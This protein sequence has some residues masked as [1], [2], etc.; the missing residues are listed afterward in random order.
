MG[1]KVQ[2]AIFVKINKLTDGNFGPKQHIK[3]RYSFIKTLQ[4]FGVTYK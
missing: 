3:K 4:F 1:I 2:M